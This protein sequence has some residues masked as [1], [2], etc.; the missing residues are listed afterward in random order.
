ML[1]LART[2]S[3]ALV[4]LR[5]G[6]TPPEPGRQG[7]DCCLQRG[8]ISV[9]GPLEPCRIFIIPDLPLLPT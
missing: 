6:A 4:E 5:G 8:I 2:E 9:Q 1:S 3:G 7:R